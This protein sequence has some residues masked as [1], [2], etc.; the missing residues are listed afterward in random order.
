MLGLSLFDVYMAATILGCGYV[1]LA[2]VFGHLHLSAGADGSGADLGHGGVEAGHEVGHPDSGQADTGAVVDAT[3]ERRRA[4]TATSPTIIASFLAG[5]GTVGLVL[6]R[7]YG[8]DSVSAVPAGVGGLLVAYFWMATYNR[9]AAAASGSSHAAVK[10][11]IGIEAVVTTPIGSAAPGAIAYTLQGSRFS[12]S[13]YS[14]DGRAIPRGER[15]TI[16]AIDDGKTFVLR[17]V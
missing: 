17:I 11:L 10:D 8:W 4:F 6:Q 14:A 2:A 5:F 1:V 12:R 16:E 15:V 3:D 9:L 7:G 13:A